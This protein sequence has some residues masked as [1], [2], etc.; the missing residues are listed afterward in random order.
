MTKTLT[1]ET[2]NPNVAVVANSPFNSAVIADWLAF[3]DV[4][5]S[6][7]VTYAKALKSF[8][9]Y[10]SNNG[11]YKPQRQD[12]ID[13]RESLLSRGYSVSSVRLY[14]VVTKKFFA[15]MASRGLYL[16]VASGVK[17]PEMPTDEHR[18]DSLTLEEAK[19][20]LSSFTGKSEKDLRN[21]CILG[22]M[23]GAGLRSIEVCRLSVDDFEKRRGQWF[24]NIRGKGRAGKEPIQISNELK[25]LVDDYLSVRVGVK[26][27]TPLFV[28]TSNR[29]RGQRLETQTVSRLA[30][31]VFAKIGVV[32]SRITCHSCRHTAAT[33]MLQAGVSIRQVQKIL[34]HRSASTTE[35]YS[36]DI[37]AFNNRGVQILSNI[38]FSKE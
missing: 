29:C 20:A 16:N 6:T 11:V 7:E 24:V 35:I 21:R 31:K 2:I 10:L 25:K 32:S 28:S 17:L 26:K 34:R 12:V 1:V 30:K 27:G 37:D 33:L 38:L 23:I 22:L 4:K 18:R 14:L 36:H 13:Y 15:W 3:I 8:L 5:P 9:G 19:Q